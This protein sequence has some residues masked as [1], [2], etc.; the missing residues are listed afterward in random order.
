MDSFETDPQTVSLY[1]SDPLVQRVVHEQ[2]AAR[3]LAIKF[4]ETPAQAAIIVSVPVR[5]G[6]LLQKIRQLS[7]S[8][9]TVSVGSFV[10]DPGLNMLISAEEDEVALTEKESAILKCLLR[11]RGAF[12]TRRD[13]LT[14]VW[15]YA[16]GVE[17]HTLETHV[18]RLRQKLEQ[19]P[20][21]PVT[22]ITAEQGYRLHV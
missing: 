17:T 10:F 14:Q 6:P 4:V 3:H 21:K 2:A 9:P 13:L 19:D 16:E 1:A 18:Y 8:A 15:G 7:F 12:V 22:L 20:A 11:A 5:L